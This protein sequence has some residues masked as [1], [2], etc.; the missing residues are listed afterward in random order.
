MSS[1]ISYH[2]T[3]NTS[4]NHR[5]VPITHRWP[6]HLLRRP[7]P[8]D[9]FLINTLYTVEEPRLSII[10]QTKYC[11]NVV[12]M[13]WTWILLILEVGTRPLLYRRRLMLKPYSN[14][15]RH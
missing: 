9:I 1:Y 3:A 6:L 4:H 2:A 5:Y 13:V 8:G 15:Y 12:C 14:K 10:H 7:Q 11:W